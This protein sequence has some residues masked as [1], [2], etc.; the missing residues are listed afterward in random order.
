MKILCFF[1]F[2]WVTSALLDPDPATQINADPQPCH[3]PEQIV[4]FHLCLLLELSLSLDLERCFLLLCMGEWDQER[5]PRPFSF[6]P[7]FTSRSE[8]GL[9]DRSCAQG[10][11]FIPLRSF[12][13]YFFQCCG[14]G[15]IFFG[16]GSYFSVGF[17]SYMNFFLNS[18]DINIPFCIP[19]SRIRIHSSEVW[20]R[21]R[22]FLSSCKNSKKRWFLLF[23]DYFWLFIFEKVKDPWTQGWSGLNVSFWIL[24]TRNKILKNIK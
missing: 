5:R 17:G 19:A 20:I 2:L 13:I 12:Y 9:G 7:R 23:C 22:I 14:S 3:I 4:P 16:S 11:H 8:P 15:M 10:G 1:L 21:I 6:R 24:W 18:L